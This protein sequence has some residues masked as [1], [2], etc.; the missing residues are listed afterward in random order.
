MFA[1]FVFFFVIEPL[2]ILLHDYFISDFWL[3]IRSLIQ[4]DF[5]YVTRY[6]LDSFS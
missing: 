1:I 5:P 2:F 6:A 4:F 3:G